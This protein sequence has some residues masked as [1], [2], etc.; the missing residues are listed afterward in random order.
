MGFWGKLGG[1]GLAA[2]LIGLCA[3]GIKVSIEERK[4]EEKR[5]NSCFSFPDNLPQETFQSIVF[6]CVKQ[7]KNKQ[8]NIK[9]E[10]ATVYGTVSSQSGL[11]NWTFSIDFNDYGMLTGK[12]WLKSENKDSLIPPRVATAIKSEIESKLLMR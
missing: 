1:A 6:H 11:T 5:I 8:I 12:Y 2:G 9:I 7:I 4:E 3:Y 10:N